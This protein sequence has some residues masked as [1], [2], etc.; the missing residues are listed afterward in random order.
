MKSLRLVVTLLAIL[1]HC[2]CDQED[3]EV[4]TIFASGGQTYIGASSNPTK[5]EKFKEFENQTVNNL[6]VYDGYLFASLMDRSANQNKSTIWRAKLIST[7]TSFTIVNETW[8]EFDIMEDSYFIQGMIVA[9]GHIYATRSDG[10]IKRCSAKRK[11]DCE[12]FYSLDKTV[13][14]GIDYMPDANE[15]IILDD[16]STLWR[17][18]PDD[19]DSCEEYVKFYNHQIKTIKSKFNSIWLGVKERRGS[20]CKLMKCPFSTEVDKLEESQCQEVR[21][22]FSCVNSI[23]FLE[24]TDRFL[25]VKRSANANI[26][27]RCDLN[28]K[29]PC[30]NL[31]T[32]S[33]LLN[34]NHEI[35][36]FV[37]VRKI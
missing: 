32:M 31:V 4:F 18:E 37:V 3:N 27:Y 19:P 2:N 33:K 15:I 9:K 22:G 1:S 25:Y 23:G 5:P 24:T 26:I 34:G 36:A 16:A 12:D 13:A 8:E 11:N 30:T 10:K 20:D 14:T 6:A 21:D 28:D 29:P 35:D 17:C 7:T